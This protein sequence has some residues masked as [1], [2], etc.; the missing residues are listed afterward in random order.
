MNDPTE[1]YMVLRASNTHAAALVY[2]YAAML[3]REGA[4]ALAQAH[5][6]LANRMVQWRDNQPQ[7][8]PAVS[9]L[10][11]LSEALAAFATVCNAV[12]RIEPVPLKPLRQGNYVLGVQVYPRHAPGPD[13]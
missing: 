9:G 3:E 11:T 12:V 6:D 4:A 13:A 2:L 7:A 5:C 8:L 10:R 1:P